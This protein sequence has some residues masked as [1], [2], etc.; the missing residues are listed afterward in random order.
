MQKGEL[1][2]QREAI[3]TGLGEAGFSDWYVQN[4]DVIILGLPWGCWTDLIPKQT[5]ASVP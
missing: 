2:L 4:C 3:C 5:R 1:N